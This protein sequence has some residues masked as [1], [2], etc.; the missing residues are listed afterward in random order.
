MIFHR[1]GK[2]GVVEM[3][4][5]SGNTPGLGLTEQNRSLLHCTVLYCV[6]CILVNWCRGLGTF[7]K[8][9]KRMQ[10]NVKNIM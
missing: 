6:Y 1:N 2:G 10:A 8:V 4:T 7:P 9:I 5:Q 3:N